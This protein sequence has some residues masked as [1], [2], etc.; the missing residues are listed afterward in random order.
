[1]LGNKAKR[2]ILR[3]STSAFFP[4]LIEITHEDYGTFRYA[5]TTVSDTIMFEGEAYSPASFSI[6]PPSQTNTGISNATLTMSAVDQEWIVKIR[7]T[8]KKASARLIEAVCMF[9]DDGEIEVESA[10]SLP[11][12]L[13]KAS[14]DGVKITWDMEFDDVMGIQVPLDV[15]TKAT[16][17]GC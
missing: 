16:V 9:N 3:S 6:D 2:E 8:D 15:A 14:W 1:M 13:A 12:T 7:S 4:Y 10:E 17:P 11:F 5:N